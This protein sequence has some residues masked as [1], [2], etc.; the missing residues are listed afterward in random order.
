M[1]FRLG[2]LALLLLSAPA[3]AQTSVR[4]S[5]TVTPGHAAIWTAPGIIQD[6]GTAANGFLTS[7]GVI[8]AGPGICQQSGVIT[9]AYNQICLGVTAT[10]G[11]TISINNYNGGTGGLSINVNGTAV[12]LTTA[13]LPTVINDVAC[14]TNTTGSIANCSPQPITPGGSNTDVQF[15]SG[16]TSLG[17]DSGFTYAGT[18][19]A[20]L[21][22]GTITTNE[23][24]LNITATWNNAST[25]FDAPLFENITNTASN[26]ASLLFDF[27]V[28][29]TSVFNSTILGPQ[30][31]S[32][33]TY[34]ISSTASASG[35]IDTGISRVGAGIVGFGN[36]TNG[37][38]SGQIQSASAQIGQFIQWPGLSFASLVSSTGRMAHITDGKASNCADTTC[39]TFGTAVTGGTG[40]LNLLV[41]YNGTNWTLFGK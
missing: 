27:Q 3:L 40:A 8:A 32:T 30:I 17:G 19:Q 14:F 23:K 12:G 13:T 31:G 18:G 6:G 16:G 33:G 9:G 11:G 37:D 22:L 10:G 5:G 15:N 26:A 41:W 35:T 4:Q 20:T 2:I 7:L 34:K 24:A 28:G 29:G 38:A 1:R 21:A 25:T 39:T 36:G